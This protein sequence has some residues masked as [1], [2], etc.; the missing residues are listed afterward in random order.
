MFRSS[1]NF[2]DGELRALSASS[3]TIIISANSTR[4]GN[5]CIVSYM[6]LSALDSGQLPF[7]LG[8]SGDNP[9]I[10]LFGV[11]TASMGDNVLHLNRS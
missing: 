11:P 5:C 1:G 9:P 6:N 3:N 8:N 7:S 2:Y 10:D 4:G